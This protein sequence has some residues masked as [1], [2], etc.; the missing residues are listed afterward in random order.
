VIRQSKSNHLVKTRLRISCSTKYRF[1]ITKTSIGS[2]TSI[3]RSFLKLTRSTCHR[4][5]LPQMVSRGKDG[6]LI[7]LRTNH[8]SKWTLLGATK[9]KR[10]T[11][12]EFMRAKWGRLSKNM[13][14]ST[15]LRKTR[16]LFLWKDK[17]WVEKA[18]SKSKLIFNR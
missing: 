9:S 12:Q 6:R 14:R 15:H 11:L 3:S 1:K 17:F 5:N 7:G 8:L 16:R 2:L 4:K 13:K 10:L 18:N